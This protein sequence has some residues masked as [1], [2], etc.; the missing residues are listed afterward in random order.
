MRGFIAI[1][2]SLLLVFAVVACGADDVESDSSSLISAID[3]DNLQSSE[4]E[5]TDNASESSDTV[6]QSISLSGTQIL[7]MAEAA[8][9]TGFPGVSFSKALERRLMHDSYIEDYS[10]LWI[11]GF[12]HASSIDDYT[13]EYERRGLLPMTLEIFIQSR[14]YEQE[15]DILFFLDIE[16]GELFPHSAWYFY[17]GEEPLI[18]SQEE[19]KEMIRGIMDFN[20]ET[21]VK[22]EM[23]VYD[24]VPDESASLQ[25][26]VNTLLDSNYTIAE[27]IDPQ[28]D[29]FRS[30]E[31]YI[32]WAQFSD[33]EIFDEF[34]HL[35]IGALVLVNAE[36]NEVPGISGSFWDF[37][38]EI[39][40]E[41]GITTT[42]IVE[43][44]FVELY[45]EGSEDPA[46]DFYFFLHMPAWTLV[47]VPW[48][49][50]IA[51]ATAWDADSESI[52]VIFVL[53][54]EQPNGAI[55][56]LYVEVEPNVLTDE[57][58]EVLETLTRWVG[59][60]FLS[61]IVASLDRA[62]RA[63]GMRGQ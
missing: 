19:L 41:M 40:D 3:E 43:I 59:Y 62:M 18:Y 17:D 61:G 23:D 26:V 29:L 56:L 4:S 60:D 6:V 28:L 42:E 14:S 25:G 57:S 1:G 24:E 34:E 8:F 49:S 48:T 2:L 54:H 15:I 45:R 11:Y 13:A 47:T 22:P 52:I 46:G 39:V 5:E 30:T 33:T 32:R 63:P 10:F 27:G 44:A 37:D 35:T 53:A 51:S 16:K 7:E 58:I 9:V 55:H 50:A 21:D 20:P 36:R 38:V 12:Y 31:V